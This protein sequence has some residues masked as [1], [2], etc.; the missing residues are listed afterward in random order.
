MVTWFLEK[1]FPSFNSDRRTRAS[2][3]AQNM[4]LLLGPISLDKMIFR[5]ISCFVFVEN[6]KCYKMSSDLDSSKI[7]KMTF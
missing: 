2:K 3:K 6:R 5:K 4:G 1:C 7:S